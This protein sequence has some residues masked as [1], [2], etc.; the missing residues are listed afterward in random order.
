MYARACAGACWLIPC[1][2]F[3]FFELRPG[4]SWL[5][6]ALLP[7]LVL[8]SPDRLVEGLHTLLRDALD[9]RVVDGVDVGVDHGGSLGVRARHEHELRVEDVGLEA[10]S[11]EAPDVL[12]SGDQDLANH[13]AA[14]PRARL[15]ALDLDAAGTTMIL[16]IIIT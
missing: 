1:Q 15:P 4:R 16:I 13:V 6:R 2:Y 7:V 3:L 14:L 11:D 9:V 10:D 12:P 5:R 8:A